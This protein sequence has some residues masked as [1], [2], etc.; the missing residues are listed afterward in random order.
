MAERAG[1]GRGE[2]GQRAGADADATKVQ[3]DE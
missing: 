2:G 3:W 1:G